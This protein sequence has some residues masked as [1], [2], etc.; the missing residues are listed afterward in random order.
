MKRKEFTNLKN[1]TLEDLTKLVREKKEESLKKKM[2]GV[3]GKDKNLK[4]YRNLRREIAQILTLI[5][6][7]QIIDKLKSKSEEVKTK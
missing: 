7:K 2:N 1:K 3:S 6:E 5:K 4:S